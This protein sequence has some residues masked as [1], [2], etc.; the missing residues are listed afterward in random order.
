MQ[1]EKESGTVYTI[2]NQINVRSA[3]DLRSASISENGL[4]ARLVSPLNTNHAFDTRYIEILHINTNRSAVDVG[5]ASTVVDATTAESVAARAAAHT[6][7]TG[8]IA[9]SASS[10]FSRILDRDE[11]SF[12]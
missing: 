1:V 3:V 6:K 7:M 11:K 5:S 8:D 12:N 4:N 10:L 2:V 9:K